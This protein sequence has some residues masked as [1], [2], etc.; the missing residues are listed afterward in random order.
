MGS[1]A[2]EADAARARAEAAEARAA[3]SAAAAEAAEGAPEAAPAPTADLKTLYRQL[4]KAIH[5]DLATDD[6][7]RV[8]RTHLMA[9][10]SEAYARGDE[11]ALRR[12]LD[13]E[14]ARP[15][16]VVG[17][18]IGA[19][20]VRVLR[21]IAQVRARLTELIELQ[22]ALEDDPM[23]TL[24]E[25]VRAATSTGEDPLGD[26]EADLHAQTRSAQARLAAL[27]AEAGVS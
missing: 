21:K 11:A 13:G 22:A 23:W 6:A 12:I 9:A 15:E 18:D 7:E 24:F 2:G 14:A 4:A 27:R 19:R 1:A 25:A 17:D 16:T 3:E 20:L 26:T 5:P 10:A 8:R